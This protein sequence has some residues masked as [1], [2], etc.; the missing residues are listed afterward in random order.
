MMKTLENL[1]GGLKFA[2]HRHHHQRSV[3]SLSMT[4]D[5]ETHVNDEEVPMEE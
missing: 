1:F 5:E 2:L 4:D 3:D